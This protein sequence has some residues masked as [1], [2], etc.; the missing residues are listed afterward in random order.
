MSSSL[1]GLTLGNYRIE[2]PLGAGGMAQVYRAVHVMLN[3]PAAIKVMHSQ[4]AANAGFQERFV[5]E[6]KAAAALNHPN[7]IDIYDF[8]RHEEN[9]LLYLVMEYIA[10]GS[11][12]TLLQH[13]SGGGEPLPTALGLDLVRQAANGLAFAHS[14]GMVHRDIKPDNLLLGDPGGQFAGRGYTVK[15]SDFGLARL[16]E[17]GIASEAGMLLGSPAY[18]SPEQCEG[19]ELD[20][21]SDLYSLGIVLYEVAT[22]YLPFEIRTASDAIYKHVSVPPLPPGQV[23][24]DLPE[25]LEAIILRC[26]AKRPAERYADATAL[27]TALTGILDRLG[28]LP[29]SPV[30][31]TQAIATPAPLGTESYIPPDVPRTTNRSSL[32]RLHVLD[33]NGQEQNALAITNRGVTVGRGSDNVVVLADKQVSRN[34]LRLD[35][36]GQRVMATDLGAANGSFLGERQLAPQT[37]TEWTAEDW[38]RVGSYW[39]YL[40]PAYN[41]AAAEA[42]VQPVIAAPVLPA[43]AAPVYS[44]PPT[45]YPPLPPS[46]VVVPGTQP[47]PYSPAESAPYS[48]PY[49]PPPSRQGR[50]NVAV[51]EGETLSITPGQSSVVRI[52]LTN[53]GTTVDHFRVTV[54]GIPEGWVTIPEQERQLNPHDAVPIVLTLT[55]AR[56]PEYTA[57]EYPVTIRARSRENPAESGEAHALWTVL[58]YTAPS[59]GIEPALATSRIKAN[60]VLSV[61]NGGNAAARYAFAGKDDESMLGYHFS[62]EIVDLDPGT[63]ARIGMT[64]QT[65]RKWL[66]RAQSRPFNAQ[67]LP[68]LGDPPQP[69]R[70]EWIQKAILPPW[71]PLVPV[72]VLALLV[73]L[74]F[75]L[76]PSVRI[77]IDP[78][79]PVAGQ[80]VTVRWDA[81][82]AR[83]ID[84][85]VDGI[86]VAKDLD[87]NGKGKIF[88]KGLGGK[89]IEA[90]AKNRLGSA[91]GALPLTV[92]QPTP[93][94]TAVPDKPVIDGFTV[95]QSVVLPGQKIKLTWKVH[96]ADSVTITSST[97][98]NDS[99]LKIDDSKE[100]TITQDTNFTITAFNKGTVTS[101]QSLFAGT[102]A[103]VATSVSQTAVVSTAASG[104][105]AVVTAA[106]QTTVAGS[107]S[108]AQTTIA[109]ST[110]AVQTSSAG[111]TAGAQTTAAGQ[112]Q[113]TQTAVA[114]ANVATQTGAANANVSTQTASANN[115]LATQTTT[116]ATAQAQSQAQSQGTQTAQAQGQGTQTAQAR[117]QTT[118]T[119]QAQGTSTAQAQAQT[120][121]TA[122]AQGTGTAV[123][124]L[125]ATAVAKTTI[126]VNEK[127]F[128]ITLNA[129]SIKAGMIIFK[130]TNDGPSLHH[131]RLLQGTTERKLISVDPGKTE[132]TDPID[133]KPG[134]YTIVC[135]IP[136]HEALGM[137][138]T[139]TVT[140]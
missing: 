84:L 6:A 48:A 45:V 116:A 41:Q 127:D 125:T 44:H 106:A 27:S 79:V 81:K 35:W 129:S 128:A 16:A 19:V 54:E 65:R 69:V 62:P 37:P 89:M 133:L 132:T 78:A 43:A 113:G 82:H 2:A 40:Q 126:T 76:Q 94:P 99:N 33:T 137:K 74:F 34:H 140:A 39:L 9:G 8:S 96:N 95:D 59:M 98:A 71:T 136:G 4:F 70:G 64:V 124:Q 93:V 139:L 15:I 61:H 105:A 58:P 85:S 86:V 24:P 102:S 75:W 21:R 20:G 104:T 29:A 47:L 117:G 63:E 88:E 123:A 30:R 57:G 72:A 80:P 32:P 111:S 36:D 110:A 28:P 87:A 38:L 122:Q 130:V 18:M 13:Q 92:V 31:S 134:V 23:R 90:V 5:Q 67:A 112:N 17:G 53:L 138:V 50:I 118:Q 56:S 83:T 14:R 3:R 11:L 73:A 119:A 52:R 26:L 68:S 77:F 101:T 107:T 135:D 66:G 42:P 115:N 55:T 109:G 22:G 51:E 108:A 131:F 114:G 49:I 100:Y 46:P 121:Q 91:K 120:T 7:I 1:V 60:Y 97:G 103:A 25:G 10:N 12:R